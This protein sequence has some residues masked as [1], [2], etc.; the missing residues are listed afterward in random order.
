MGPRYAD[1]SGASSQIFPFSGKS[2]LM[3]INIRTLRPGLHY[4]PEKFENGA[5]TLKMY[6][7]FFVYTMLEISVFEKNSVTG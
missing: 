6:E 1:S 7:M 4:T 2:R 5:F 3:S